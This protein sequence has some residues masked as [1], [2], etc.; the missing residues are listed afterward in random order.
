MKL[1]KKVL[2]IS[3]LLL[4]CI[5]SITFA[6]NTKFPSVT[7][8]KYI[9]D[10]TGTMSKNYTEKIISIG[11][12]L[13]EK[14]TAQCVIV[15]INSTNNVPIEKYANEL[16]RSW[17]I[18][19]SEKNNGLLI[20]LA[21]DDRNWR[22]EVGKGLEGAVP[23]VLSN[24]IMTSYGKPYFRD[25]NYNDGLLNCYYEFSNKIAEEY[26][27]SLTSLENI[28]VSSKDYNNN[29]SSSNTSNKVI[30]GVIILLIFLD[31]ILNR[32]RVCRTFLQMIIISSH[33]RGPRGGGGGFGGG[34]SG[35]GGGN[36]GGNGGFGGGSS[37]GGG[38]SG[39]W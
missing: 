10:Y 31:I 33:H 22:V 36:S 17:G 1:F 30:P 21:M 19:T 25:G 39:S 23:D 4:V 14:T 35:F 26:G 9:N 7:T 20:L 6:A 34:S 29:N 18:G 37:N 38:S 16:F 32:G 27:V 3:S 8:N 13:E 24:K 11:K 5:Y 2:L 28:N 12:E 15:V